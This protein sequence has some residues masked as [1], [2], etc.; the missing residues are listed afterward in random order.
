MV[1]VSGKAALK[2]DKYFKDHNEDGCMYIQQPKDLPLA[3]WGGLKST[4]AYV[5]GTQGV[6]ID[7][8]IRDVDE[9]EEMKFPASTFAPINEV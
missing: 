9:H 1:E 5:L 8:R 4:R 2:H 3:C 6:V 7:G